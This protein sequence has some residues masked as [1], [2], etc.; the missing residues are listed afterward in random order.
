MH[1]TG[2]TDDMKNE[3]DIGHNSSLRIYTQLF[4]AASRGPHSRSNCFGHCFYF[5]ADTDAEK[6]YFRIIS[7]VNSDKNIKFCLARTTLLTHYVW[8]SPSFL[9][10]L[11]F[12]RP[13]MGRSFYA[14]SDAEPC[15]RAQTSAQNSAN[16]S[17]PKSAK[18]RKRVQK[19]A[20][21]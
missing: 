19:S 11:G 18:G 6:Y 4:L 3:N 15:R 1:F 10:M 12:Q 14:R 7:A 5:I 13:I 17:L 20:S 16:A 21:A 8:R 9:K 2:D